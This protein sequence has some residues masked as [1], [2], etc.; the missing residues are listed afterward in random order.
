[1]FYHFQAVSLYVSNPGLPGQRYPHYDEFFSKYGS[2]AL[3]RQKI[4][5][6]GSSA[7]QFIIIP[8][9]LWGA[10]EGEQNWISL[11]TNFKR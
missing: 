3:L 8:A 9:L 1:M 6:L 5:L 11:M 4:E 10:E 7:V 2:Y